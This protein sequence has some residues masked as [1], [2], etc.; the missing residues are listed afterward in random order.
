[1]QFGGARRFVSAGCCDATR[2]VLSARFATWWMEGAAM[3][4][5]SP[6]QGS[7]GP[8]KNSWGMASTATHS[9]SRPTPHLMACQPAATAAATP[10]GA[11]AGEMQP[12]QPHGWLERSNDAVSWHA[13]REAEGMHPITSCCWGI[14]QAAKTCSY[15]NMAAARFASA[16]HA[17][18]CTA[19]AARPLPRHLGW[20]RLRQ[21]PPYR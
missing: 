15:Q 9:L 18:C 20:C 7:P 1:M 8:W 16:Y 3:L 6:S 5:G 2:A 19:A 13:M 21:S 14:A 11:R 12:K 4:H 10:A 17:A